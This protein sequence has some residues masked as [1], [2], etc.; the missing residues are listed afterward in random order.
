MSSLP[1]LSLE[2][3]EKT[4]KGAA[5]A[6][7]RDGYVPGTLYG[8]ET[9]E[10]IQI[11]QSDF[12]KEMQNPGIKTRVYEFELAGKKFKGL[13]RAIER[14]LLSELPLHFDVQK[15]EET[16]TLKI[17]VPLKFINRD[18]CPGLKRGG[19]LSLIHHTLKVKCLASKIVSHIVIDLDGA[20]VG[21]SIRFSDIQLPEGMS[22]LNQR[23]QDTVYTIVPPKVKGKDAAAADNAA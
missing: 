23:M 12:V 7:R 20:P 21:K 22:F 8:Q 16:T 3:R 1:S 17:S 13:V 19:V 2:T 6:V 18:K 5:R 9:P 11:L 14:D 15:I 10:S 4:G